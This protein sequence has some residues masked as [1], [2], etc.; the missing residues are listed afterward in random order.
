MDLD[1]RFGPSATAF[2]PV[3]P[4]EWSSAPLSL[5]EVTSDSAPFVAEY[6]STQPR[7]KL[8]SVF[9]RTFHLLW[10]MD[11][12][13]RLL[14]AVEELVDTNGVV[15]GALPNTIFARPTSARKLG[16]PSLLTG[17]SREA[18]IGGEIVFDPDWQPGTDWVLTNKS[19]RYGLRPWQTERHLREVHGLFTAF[20]LYLGLRFITP[21][22]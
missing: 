6:L 15:I 20:S 4:H 14:I 12:E 8:T 5:M 22:A 21:L 3:E 19:G 17:A 1:A 9:A 18:R 16:H 13:G 7:L 2:R 11:G 10:L